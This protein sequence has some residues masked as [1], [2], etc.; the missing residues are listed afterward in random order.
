MNFLRTIRF[1][2]VFI[3]SIFLA[4]CGQQAAPITY[5]TVS[6]GTLKPGDPIPVPTG[7]VVLTVDGMIEQKNSGETLQFDIA[8]LES[9]GL[10]QYDVDDPFIKKNILYT[11]VLLSQL[12]DA[13]GMSPDATIITLHALDDYSTDMKI[14]DADKWPVLVATQADGAYMAVDNN[15]PL[16]SIFPFNDYPEIDHLTYDALWVWSL[17][18]ITVK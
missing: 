6:P 13:A 8:A 15:G 11:G 16:I 4:A 18:A 9:I 17:S 14:S 3:F 5:E 12:L 1:N 10:V 7:D 2:L